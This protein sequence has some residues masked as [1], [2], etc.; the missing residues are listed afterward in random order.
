M[1]IWK[2]EKRQDPQFLLFKTKFLTEKEALHFLRCLLFSQNIILKTCLFTI[3]YTCN[4]T[5]YY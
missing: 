5:R 4:Y 3:I 1:K 2:P